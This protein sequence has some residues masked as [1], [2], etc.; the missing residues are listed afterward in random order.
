MSLYF[1]IFDF[2]GEKVNLSSPELTATEWFI[3]KSYWEECHPK[4]QVKDI[5][6]KIHYVALPSYT[7]PS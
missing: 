7:I 4:V 5:K 6:I 3:Q 2:F 1:M